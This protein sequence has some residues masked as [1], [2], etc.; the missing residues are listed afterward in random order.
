M[1]APGLSVVV[2]I[3]VTTFFGAVPGDI[4]FSAFNRHSSSHFSSFFHLSHLSF[5]LADSICS[6]IIWILSFVISAPTLQFVSCLGGDSISF[7][8]FFP[9][10]KPPLYLVVCCLLDPRVRFMFK[11]RLH[12][13]HLLIFLSRDLVLSSIWSLIID[14]GLFV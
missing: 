1:T 10:K 13:F 6:G 2:T 3:C 5:E 7:H 8:L 9:Y 14:H 12:L 4:L 11:W